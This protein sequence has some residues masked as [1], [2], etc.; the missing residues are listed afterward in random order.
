MQGAVTNHSTLK[1]L[2]DSIT[3]LHQ[4]LFH[5]TL[6]MSKRDSCMT[7]VSSGLGS[8][9]GDEDHL[10]LTQ[11]KICCTRRVVF[12][13]CFVAMSLLVADVVAAVGM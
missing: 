5:Y 11:R 7:S 8:A 12:C 3:E 9:A 1:V 2:N 4:L 6:F 13:S 10:I